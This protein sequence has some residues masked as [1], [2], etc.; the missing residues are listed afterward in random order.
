MRSRIYMGKIIVIGG[1][2]NGLIAANYLQRNGFQVTLLEKKDRV[3]GACSFDSIKL[4]G[5]TYTYPNG[6]TLLGFMQDFIFKETGLDKQLKIGCSKHPDISYVGSGSK[7]FIEH[8]DIDKFILEA[9]EKFGENGRLKLFFKDL[10]SVRAFVIDGYKKAEVP[11]IEQAKKQ[12][13]NKLTELW[14]KGSAKK[15]LD[16]YFETEQMKLLISAPVKE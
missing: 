8:D 15:L 13:G 3:G 9:K 10:D 6:A 11:T 1:G 14:I 5:K 16:Y 4:R 2:I 12:L 7:P